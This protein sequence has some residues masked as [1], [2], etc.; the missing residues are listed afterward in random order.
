[1]IDR[2]MRHVDKCAVTGC[3]NWTG[4]KSTPGKGRKEGGSLP[5]G[6]IKVDGKARRAHRVSYELLVG[7]IPHGFVIDHICRNT[8]CC[9]PD[10]L[11]AMTN[12]ENIL[13]GTSATSIA[14]RLP[15]YVILDDVGSGP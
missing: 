7:P 13:I 10:H 4:A 5:Y 3:W 2:L 6:C 1:M 14:R 9:N 12:R 8:L 15:S 11:R